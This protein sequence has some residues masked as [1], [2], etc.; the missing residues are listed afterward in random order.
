MRV[1]LDGLKGQIDG[2]TQEVLAGEP[3]DVNS[4]ET[5]DKVAP[6]LRPFTATG[7]SFVAD[8]P[9]H[10]VTVYRLKVKK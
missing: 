3:G 2:G 1:T 10:S 7:S 5:P 9:A 4:V 6:V 8:F